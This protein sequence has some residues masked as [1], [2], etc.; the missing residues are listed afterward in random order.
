MVCIYYRVGNV[1]L[2][3]LISLFNST[4]GRRKVFW[5]ITY[6][7]TFKFLIT[8]ARCC[9]KKILKK[10]KFFLSLHF[11]EFH[12]QTLLYVFTVKWLSSSLLLKYCAFLIRCKFAIKSGVFPPENTWHRDLDLLLLYHPCGW[13]DFSCLPLILFMSRL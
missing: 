9:F 12:S 2:S 7:V 11:S 13:G 5:K 1:S 4:L 3:F 10:K 8:C 6:S